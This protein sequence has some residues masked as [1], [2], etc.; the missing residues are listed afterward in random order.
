LIRITFIRK[1]DSFLSQYAFIFPI[2]PIL[3]LNN[4]RSTA[5]PDKKYQNGPQN[6]S[7]LLGNSSDYFAKISPKDK[8]VTKKVNKIDLGKLSLNKN[9]FDNDSWRDLFSTT[10]GPGIKTDSINWKEVKNN[11]NKRRVRENKSTRVFD[12]KNFYF[13]RDRT[14]AKSDRLTLGMNSS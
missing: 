3:I 7:N 4:H 9:N 2:P 1:K 12:L 13:A 11:Y 14:H 10:G 8:D 5:F 6:N